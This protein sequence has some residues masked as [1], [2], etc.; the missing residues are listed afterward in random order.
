MLWKTRAGK[1]PAAAGVVSPI[2]GLLYLAMASDF[3]AHDAAMRG[4]A[5]ALFACGGMDF[6][7]C[8]LA[9]AAILRST[10]PAGPAAAPAH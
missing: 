1:A 9:V 10:D 7:A 6:A 8:A 3:L 4:T 5:M 2:L